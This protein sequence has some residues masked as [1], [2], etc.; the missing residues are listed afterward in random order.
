MRSVVCKIAECSKQLHCASKLFSRTA[1][2]WSSLNVC[3]FSETAL[4]HC[5]ISPSLFFFSLKYK[6]RTISLIK[7]EKTGKTY[8]VTYCCT[9]NSSISC[10]QPKLV[11]LTFMVVYKQPEDYI[12]FTICFHEM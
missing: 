5:M 1:T 7:H 12:T 2:R 10:S 4:E 9:S 8:H 6:N 3:S 11:F